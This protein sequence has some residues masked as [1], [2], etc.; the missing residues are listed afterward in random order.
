MSN[1]LAIATVTAAL[2]QNVRA[3]VQSILPGA[4][5]L[6]ERPDN[7]ASG[8]P[9]VR[10]F[11]YQI[12]TNGA[13]RNNDL[14]S[15]ASN[16]SLTRRP[17][18]ALD[19]HYLLSFYGSEKDLEPHRMLG[20]AMR[21]LHGKPVLTR[22]M[23]IDVIASN[24][25]LLGSDLA[26]GVEQVKFTPSSLSLE[27]LSRLW[28]VFFQAPYALS[29][30]CEAAV[31]LI[32]GEEY[33]EPAPPVLS[34]GKDDQ[35]IRLLLGSFPVIES[36]HIGASEDAQRRPRQPSY[37]AAQQ[38][39]VVTIAG[40]NLGGET[41][42][43]RFDHTRLDIS[44]MIVVPFDARSA[45]EVRVTLPDTAAAHTNWAAGFYMVAIV[46]ENNG[47]ARSTNQLP[48]SFAAS[49]LGIV[50]P[51]PVV[52]DISG[53]VTLTI[54]CSPQVRPS[55]RVV[56]LI[57]NR[58]VVVSPHPTETDS[59]EFVMEHAPVISNALVRLR[60]DG[61]DSLPYRRSV[62]PGPPVLEFDGNQKVSIS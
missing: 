8:S 59:L 50:P 44:E 43:V 6:T 23:I 36:I 56:L 16:G 47:E 31:V 33:A 9:R 62:I 54:T 11:L 26:D 28:S 7:T 46:V 61:V 45:T 10:V 5:V 21:D 25:M 22:Q 53:K 1:A 34:R 13:L 38:G 30:A 57:A 55:Q 12:S 2:A 51:N 48:L 39:I 37:P 40:R 32:D 58:E 52:R 3:A 15:R 27:D 19:L 49:I 41:V 60:I 14:P 42:R 18:I 4:E 35:G 24:P 17:T 29:V 20:A